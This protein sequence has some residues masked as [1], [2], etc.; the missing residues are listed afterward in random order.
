MNMIKPKYRTRLTDV[1]LKTLMRIATT[2]IEVDFDLLIN[3]VCAVENENEQT[4]IIKKNF[5]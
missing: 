5:E 4:I 1:N 2:K 3:N